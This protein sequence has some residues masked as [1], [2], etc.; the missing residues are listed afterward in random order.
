[1]GQPEIRSANDAVFASRFTQIADVFVRAAV[2]KIE[3]QSLL[4]VLHCQIELPQ[5]AIQ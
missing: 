5:P 3:G 1:V 2:P 4:I